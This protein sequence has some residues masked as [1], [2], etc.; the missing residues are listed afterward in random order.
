MKDVDQED[1][2]ARKPRFPR[3]RTWGLVV[4]LLAVGWFLWLQ[5]IVRKALLSHACRDADQIVVVLLAPHEGEGEPVGRLSRIT[6][7]IGGKDAV[8]EFLGLIRLRPSIPGLTVGLCSDVSIELA[9][10]D[11]A[12]ATLQFPA[13]DRVRCD[14]QWFGDA[15]I[16]EPTGRS[17]QAWIDRRGGDQLKSARAQAAEL[18]KKYREERARQTA[19]E[20]AAATSPSE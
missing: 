19:Q 6:V 11:Q 13:L 8:S 18:W 14:D 10:S 9:K 1:E 2:L 17:L 7:P 12:V 20:Q 3:K 4:L 5:P 15:S 16:G